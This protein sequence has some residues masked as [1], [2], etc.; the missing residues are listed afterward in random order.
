[1]KV[2]LDAARERAMEETCR[3][4]HAWLGYLLTRLGTDVL[5]VKVEDIRQ[6][7]TTFHCDV[8]REGD[9]YVIRLTD[10]ANGKGDRS[11]A[12]DGAGA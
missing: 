8:T 5:R 12:D 4:Y 7:L 11:H 6:A 1:M 3:L 10:A 9:A 2:K